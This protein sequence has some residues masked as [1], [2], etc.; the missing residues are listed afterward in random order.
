MMMDNLYLIC[1]IAGQPVAIH[2]AK[3]ESV[4]DIG[5]VSPVPLAP[6]HVAGLAALRSRLLTIICCECAL[7]LSQTP[8]TGSRAVIVAVDGHHYGLLVGTIDDARVIDR[9]IEPVRARLQPGWARVA[10][11]MIEHDGE[12]LLLVDPEK[13]IAGGEDF[14]VLAS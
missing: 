2:A 7:G 10:I 1:S 4:V 9:E 5:A 12:A 13:L 8:C 6:P 3:V 11:G 14:F